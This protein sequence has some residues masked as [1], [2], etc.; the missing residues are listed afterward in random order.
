MGNMETL[1]VYRTEL[2]AKVAVVN[3]VRAEVNR[4]TPL[5]IADFTPLV[6]QKIMKSCGLMAK[7]EHL[8]PASNAK[9]QV[10]RNGSDYTL[11]FT[12]KSDSLFEKE[13]EFANT[14]HH[15]Q[16]SFY[17]EETIYIGELNGPILVSIM[18][19][20]PLKCDYTV[21]EVKKARIKV[22]EAE[23]AFSNAKS[24]LSPFSRY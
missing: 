22:E 1:T 6:G 19:F 23:D 12:I 15:Y 5:V 16:S 7:F 4:L 9:F 13:N 2:E 11:S 24:T 17:H 21:D 14:G 10:F 8:K 20:E 3:K 18:K